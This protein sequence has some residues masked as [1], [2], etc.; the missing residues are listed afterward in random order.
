MHKLAESHTV[1]AGFRKI[2]KDFNYQSI[3]PVRLDITDYESCKSVTSKIFRLE[4]K[5]DVLL[6]IA[7][8]SLAGPS[9]DFEVKDYISI[10]DTNTVGAFRL[11][12]LVLPHM[13]K[14]K[15]GRIIN[16]TSLNGIV[17]LPNFG[18]YS[19][20]KF[21][22]EALG[23]SL[24]YEVARYGVWITNIAPGAILSR[25]SVG[26]KIPHKPFREKFKALSL[27]MPMVTSESIAEKIQEIIENPTPPASV[28]L[29]GDAQITCFLQ[30]VLPSSLWDKLLFFIW[31]KK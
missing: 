9:T 17:A 4:G 29:G 25:S 14:Q 22:L 18:L 24:R 3:T 28:L 7:G 10:L 31:N 13:K 16:I 15:N 11:M 20:S 30:K 6:N 12:K 26:S 19:S 8:Y 21:A 1:Y 5:I 23:R 27:L 2:P